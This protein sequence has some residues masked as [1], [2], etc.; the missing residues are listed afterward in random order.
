VSD[1]GWC[2]PLVLDINII[3][4]FYFQRT[5]TVTLWDSSSVDLILSQVSIAI[6]KIFNLMWI[7][8]S[9]WLIHLG[10]KMVILDN[11]GWNCDVTNI[12]IAIYKITS[13]YLTEIDNKILG[14]LIYWVP[15]NLAWVGFKL[16]TFISI[17]ECNKK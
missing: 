5:A 12:F 6:T 16:T 10:K 15:V 11:L 3:I 2:G 13:I 4:V 14:I 9:D 7:L 1:S 8:Q 17:C